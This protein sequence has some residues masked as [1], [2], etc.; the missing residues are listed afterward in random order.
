MLLHLYKW[1]CFISW[2]DHRR[3]YFSSFYPVMYSPLIEFIQQ[4]I[5]VKRNS[6]SSRQF[7]R[8]IY[9]LLNNGGGMLSYLNGF[10]H[11]K[12]FKTKKKQNFRAGIGPDGV[13]VG[14]WNDSGGSYNICFTRKT[15]LLFL[16]EVR[17]K[18]TYFVLFL[19]VRNDGNPAQALKMCVCIY[20]YIYIY[21]PLRKK[22]KKK[23]SQPEYINFIHVG[24]YVPVY[25]QF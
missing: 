16:K 4:G 5:Y 20:I 21:N 23:N 18:N 10:S 1:Q 22:N 7:A 11:W 25:L 19:L 17:N 2:E 14:S 15:V 24:D 3:Q 6:L 12:S 13:K 9:F 8:V